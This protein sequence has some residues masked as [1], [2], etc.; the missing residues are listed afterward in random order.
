MNY[1]RYI[2]SILAFFILYTK[3]AYLIVQSF[4]RFIDLPYLV[5][6]PLVRVD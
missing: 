5:T 2:D 3:M 6:Y 4:V 1:N